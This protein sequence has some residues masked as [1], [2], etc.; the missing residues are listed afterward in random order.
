MPR[1][2]RMG[3]IGG[4]AGAF[5]GA[6]HRMAAAM[7][8]KIDFVCGA[9]SSTAN[10]S[11][12]SGKA[13][14]LPEN[15]IYGTYQEMLQKEAALPADERMDFVS[16]VTPTGSHY[17][18]LCNVLDAGWNVVCD[19]PM[20]VSLEEAM[21]I[22]KKVEA[23]NVLFCL[24]HNYTGY[25]MVKQAK[26]MAA[27]GQIGRIRRVVVEFPQGWLGAVPNPRE[28]K[29]A[30]WR[31]DA[32][33][34]VSF[35]MADIGSHCANLAEYI[36]G[37]NIE[38]VCADLECWIAS[39]LDDDGSVLLRFSGGAK[40]VLW[41]SSVLAGEENNLKIRVYG[42]KGSLHWV[43]QEPNTLLVTWNDKASEII[44]TGTPSASPYAMSVTR[45][46][47]GHP[48]GFI[49]AFANIY[50]NFADVLNAKLK[51]EDY[52]LIKDHPD[53]DSGVR[54]VAFIDAALRSSEK[55]QWVELN[56]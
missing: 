41:A 17:K 14:G 4:G 34:G 40:G 11:I 26:E 54:G 33:S 24:T 18:I 9:L 35:T 49:E 20:T 21:D 31:M 23:K 16:I 15:R 2:L 22:K 56:V 45:L 7:D 1:K 44:R 25:P 53:V 13:L 28:H 42:E 50:S 39:P 36:S 43:Q 3:M 8:G 6:V 32:S 48:E 10:K 51:G 30:G 12:E 19:K 47:A 52:S 38:K 5:I 27:S 29:Q 37:L 55:E 46:P